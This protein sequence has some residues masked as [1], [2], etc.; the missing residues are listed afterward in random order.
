MD[1][2]ERLTEAGLVVTKRL[3]THLY[4]GG[5][6]DVN[7]PDEVRGNTREYGAPKSILC[8][9]D[10]QWVFEVHCH[11]PGPGPGDFTLTFPSLQLAIDSIID[12]YFDD[13]VRM[14]PPQYVHRK[15]WATIYRSVFG[16][17]YIG[18][19]RCCRI[20]CQVQ[21]IA[22]NDPL[23]HSRGRDPK[24]HYCA[25]HLEELELLSKQFLTKVSPP[26]EHDNAG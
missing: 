10:G 17:S 13:P 1:K 5:G 22:T 26:P 24:S 8:E 21:T 23:R 2:L 4:Y 18:S 9:I 14:N 25:E 15:K 6:Y 3:T 7:K 11:A 20:G 16:P 12:Y 19:T